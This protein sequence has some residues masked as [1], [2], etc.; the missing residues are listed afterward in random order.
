M[1]IAIIT[2]VLGEENNGT[3]ITTMR[4]IENMKQKAMRFLL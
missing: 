4:L 3:T 1:K 2:D